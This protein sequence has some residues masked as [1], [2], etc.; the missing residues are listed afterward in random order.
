MD[1]FQSIVVVLIWIVELFRIDINAEACM[2]SSHPVLPREG[3]FQELLHVFACIKKH[4]NNEMVLD[5]SEPDIDM[6][7]F[8]LQY[9]RYSIYSF[10]DEEIREALPPNMSQSI[11]NGFPICCFLDA[12][13]AGESL[14]HRFRTGFIV[15]LKNALIY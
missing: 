8:R 1:H 9:W 6:N 7:S 11:V 2:F 3:H 5:P 14:T 12:D 10:P 13:H 4:M 15:M